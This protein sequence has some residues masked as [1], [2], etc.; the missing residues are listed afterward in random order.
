MKWY[1]EMNQRW[2]PEERIRYEA[3][4]MLQ[5]LE[6]DFL[7]NINNEKLN[8]KLNNEWRHKKCLW[9]VH[10]PIR[11]EK[12]PLEYREC[13][14]H[15]NEKKNIYL[16]KLMQLTHRSLLKN[17]FTAMKN[18]RNKHRGSAS[19]LYVEQ[20]WE[21]Y[22]E[23]TKRNSKNKKI[24]KIYLNILTCITI[25]ERIGSARSI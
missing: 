13:Q 23:N 10:K 25:H 4:E 15:L 3:N 1:P 19:S 21:Y 17:A 16:S 7:A 9:C 18:A 2:I 8:N 6:K 24:T 11:Q 14:G 22:W 20:L 12:V 5:A